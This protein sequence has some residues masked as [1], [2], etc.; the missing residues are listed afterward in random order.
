MH[1]KRKNIGKFWPVPRKGT[2]YLAVPSHNNS[3][4]ISLV[5]VIRDVLKLVRNKKELKRLLNYLIGATWYGFINKRRFDMKEF[6]TEK[7]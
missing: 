3:E 6:E 7:F 1:I 5:V 2:K 4:S